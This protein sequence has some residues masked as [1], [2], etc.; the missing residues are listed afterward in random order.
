MTDAERVE[1]VARIV[2]GWSRDHGKVW[3]FAP[4]ENDVDSCLLLDRLAELYP[5]T[6]PLLS[7]LTIS[8]RRHWFCSLWRESPQPS[9]LFSGQGDSLDAASRRRAILLCACAVAEARE[10]EQTP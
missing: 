5:D 9:P 1:L 8:N 10:T 4:D 2:M 6:P 7:L 3:L